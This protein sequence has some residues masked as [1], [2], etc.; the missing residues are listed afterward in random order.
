MLFTHLIS[1]CPSSFTKITLIWSLDYFCCCFW[2]NTMCTVR[3]TVCHSSD[4]PYLISS[5]L[6]WVYVKGVLPW[7]RSPFLMSLSHLLLCDGCGC[8]RHFASVSECP[9]K[10]QRPQPLTSVTS[11]TQLG[12]AGDQSGP[13]GLRMEQ[14]KTL[15]ILYVKEARGSW[16]DRLVLRGKP[17]LHHRTMLGEF[18]WSEPCT[19]AGIPGV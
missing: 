9:Q 12:S 19:V 4:Q 6:L 18:C 11:R 7:P 17:E 2:N 5:Q 15:P 1:I 8:S 10:S 13:L 16:G 14:R 3:C